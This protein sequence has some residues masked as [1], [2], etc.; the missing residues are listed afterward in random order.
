MGAGLITTPRIA[1]GFTRHV[2]WTHTVSTALRF[3]LFRLDL[4]AG[5]PMTYRTG[6]ETRDIVPVPVAIEVMQG[7]GSIRIEDRTI[8]MTHLGPVLTTAATPWTAEY[9]YVIRDVNYENDRGGD[10]YHDISAARSVAEIRQALE[11]HQGVS[12]VNTVAADVEGNALYADLSSVPHVTAGQIE[13]C[14]TGPE[15]VDRWRVIVLNGSDPTCDWQVDESA[16]APGLMPPSQLPSL[17]TDTYVSNSNDSHWLT[18]PDQPLE[19]YS[20]IIGNEKAQRSLRTRAGL[21]FIEEVLKRNERFTP[22]IVQALLYNHRHYGAELLLDD[23]LLV[24]EG[25][26]VTLDIAA[27]CGILTAWDRRTD[28]DSVGAHIYHELWVAIRGEIQNH[29]K[30]PFDINDPLHTPRGLTTEIAATRELVMNGLKTAL[31]KLAE[32]NVQTSAPW[33]EVQF[34]LV[35]GEKIGIPGGDGGAGIYSV[36]SSGLNKETGGYNPI[37]HGNSYIQVVTWNERGDPQAKAILTY[38]QSPE[39]DS[40]HFADQTRLYSKSEWI[41]L[42]FTDAEIEADTQR[43]LDLGAGNR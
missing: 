20:P 8:Y 14:A 13:R 28:I 32:A 37:F 33:G 24:C 10:Q 43:R 6:A 12:F 36:I 18:N 2:A 34:V 31:E 19:G 30:V 26:G 38:S 21:V 4:V 3:T 7:D 9:V 5:D 11:K 42:P 22:E 17:I 1:M 29:F 23:L 27:A 40:P 41:T 25:E 16:A 39:P 35:D 15:R